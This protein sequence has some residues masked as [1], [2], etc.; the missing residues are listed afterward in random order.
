MAV[1]AASVSLICGCGCGVTLGAMLQVGVHTLGGRPCVVYQ[2]SPQY[3]GCGDYAATWVGGGLGVRVVQVLDIPA[4]LWRGAARRAS[5]TCFRP[6]R[7]L[8][9]LSLC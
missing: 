9:R 4:G 7:S 2:C 6:A 8:R 1:A 5:T 3:D